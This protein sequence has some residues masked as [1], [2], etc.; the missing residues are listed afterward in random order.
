MPN[1][2]FFS[3]Q[4][5]GETYAGDICAVQGMECASGDTFV[6]D[7]KQKLAMVPYTF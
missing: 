6:H 2:F 3:Q 7:P 4:D 1:M 5:V